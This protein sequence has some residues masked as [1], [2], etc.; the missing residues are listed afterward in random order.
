MFAP[1]S[2][3]ARSRG[4]VGE[5]SR[6][7]TLRRMY[8]GEEDLHGDPSAFRCEVEASEGDL[9]FAEACRFC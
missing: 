5:R 9:R 6:E 4:A 7:S 2:L 1:A 3:L 8:R